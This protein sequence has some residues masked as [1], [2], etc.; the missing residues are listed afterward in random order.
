MF[1]WI[2]FLKKLWSSFLLLL[3]L[4]VVV[5]WITKVL[6]QML[7]IKHI[8]MIFSISI[9]REIASLLFSGGVTVFFLPYTKKLLQQNKV[10]WLGWEP[11]IE[12]GNIGPVG[13]LYICY[14]LLFLVYVTFPV[15]L[16]NSFSLYTQ[17]N[18]VLHHKDSNEFTT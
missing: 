6:K 8:R 16:C 12:Q 2:Y 9:I 15:I 17:R 5:L 3:L 10:L 13:Q 11:E 7:F 4:F 14:P 18:N 1:A